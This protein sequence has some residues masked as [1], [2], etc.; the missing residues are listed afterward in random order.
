MG[1][2]R[3]R[4]AI[5]VCL[6]SFTGWAYVIRWGIY[7]H[8]KAHTLPDWDDALLDTS[9]AGGDNVNYSHRSMMGSERSLFCRS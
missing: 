1:G 9:Y 7:N 2:V 4:H 3:M 5:R 6:V 8:H